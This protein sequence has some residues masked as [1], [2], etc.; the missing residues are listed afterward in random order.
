M[1]ETLDQVA[2]VEDTE[3]KA[4][5]NIQKEIEENEFVLEDAINL[6]NEEKIEEL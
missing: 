1:I 4:E 5:E 3:S 6:N 2:Q